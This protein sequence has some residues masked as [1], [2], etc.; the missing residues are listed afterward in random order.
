M[1]RR[2]RHGGARF[3]QR[4]SHRTARVGELIRRIVAEGMERIGD[5]R[6]DLVSVTDVTVDRDL[7]RALVWYTTLSD[8][9]AASVA[10]AFEEHGPRLRRSVGQQA[11][12]RK[13]PKLVFKPD[14]V[15][16]AA[17][18]IEDLIARSRA[19]RTGLGESDGDR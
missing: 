19:S 14:E 17:E 18:H 5:E 11:H 10:E 6:L 15:I 7:N 8:D 3:D 1:A 12:L 2:G 9:D 16:R 13:T 4:V